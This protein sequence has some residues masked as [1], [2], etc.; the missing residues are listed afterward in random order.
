MNLTSK[1]S[2][3]VFSVTN[4]IC[5]DQRVLKMANTVS[6]LNCDITIVG[7]KKGICCDSD[8]VPFR[9][10]RFGM[11]FRRGFLFYKWFN[12]RLF[13]YLLSH[14][15][16]ILVAND[17]DT[18]LPNFLISKLKGLPLVYDSHEYFTGVPELQNRPFIRWIWKSIEKSTFPKLK[19]VITV[20]DSIADQYKIEYGIRPLT[21]RNCS[22]NTS[23]IKPIIRS[24]IG[25]PTDHLLL[26]YQGTGINVS[27]G[28]DELI[29]AISLTQNVTLL[30]IGSGDA[31]DT[32]KSKVQE[33]NLGERV[34]FIDK[35]PW[36][37]LMKYTKSADAGLSL[38]KNNNLNYA[39]SLPNKLFD[40]LS[41]G[42]PVIAGD[43]PEVSKIISENNCG[44]II[45]EV[46]SHKISEALNEL[47]SNPD[48]LSLLQKN[49]VIASQKLNWE[50]ESE[51]VTKLYKEI[52]G[53]KGAVA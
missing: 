30:I 13:I 41:A 32:L 25:I 21:V 22:H 11:L 47:L 31:L 36:T 24:E 3:I 15:F 45:S 34:R 37:E 29:D 44:I 2:R 4:C 38:D 19:Y 42:I 7:R 33:L 51:I 8:S 39:F 17:L 43:L 9:T 52:L 5:F 14:R 49:A 50:T 12:I 46:T 10:K 6:S 28:G 35:L 40:Y 20:S 16:D 23:S 53:L 27:R 48:K 1:N 18:L 26:V